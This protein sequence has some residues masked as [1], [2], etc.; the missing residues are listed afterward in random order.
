MSWTRLLVARLRALR[1]GSRVREE[2]DEEYQF[3]ID[4]RT[5]ENVARGMSHDDARRDAEQR[6]G[7]RSSI[8]EAGYDLRGGGW[9]ETLWQ[10]LRFGTRGLARNRGFAVVAVLTLGLGIGANTAIFSVINAVFLRPLPFAN[11]D[12]LVM[13]QMAANTP[14]TFND[15]RNESVVF[16]DMAAARYRDLSITGDGEPE[17]VIA[18]GITANL[19]PLLGVEP[20]LGRGF[21]A[22]E[23]RAD[24]PRVV[25]L[26]DG[27]WRRRFGAATDVVG[28][29]VRLNGELHTIV[30]VMPAEFQIL[31]RPADAWVPMAFGPQDLT[32][33]RSYFLNVFAR[34]APDVTVEQAD[35]ATAALVDRIRQAHPDEV[36]DFG[37]PVVPLREVLAGDSRTALLVLLVAVGLVLL[38][39]CIN[40]GNLL[41]SR[42]AARRREITVRA[43]L[44]ATSRR[45]LQQ[46]LVENVPLVACGTV[47]GL[48][49]AWSSM[50][51][52]GQL[53]PPAMARSTALTLDG[54]VL[55]VTLFVAVLATA[56]FGV[57]PA[58]HLARADLNGALRLAGART[59][60]STGGRLQSALIVGEVS[61]AIAL[62][63][64]AS[65]LIQSFFQL[66]GQY[67]D[68]DGER[69]ITMKTAMT[70]AGAEAHGRRAAFV[71]AVL[72]RVRTVPGVVAAGYTNALP[73]DYKG[74]ATGV[75]VEGEEPVAEIENETNT[76]LVTPDFLRALGVELLEGRH[77][78]EA[79]APDAMSVAIV[80]RAMVRLYWHG[81]DPIGRRFKVDDSEH[82]TPWI[83][84][85][86]VVEDLRQ[87]NVDEPARPEMYLPYVQAT[88]LEVFAPRTLAIR[89]IGDR[90]HVLAAVRR[91]IAAVNPNQP[92][93]EVRTMS[94]IVGNELAARRTGTLL[95]GAFASIALLLASVG[96]YGLLAHRVRQMTPEIGVRMALGARPRDMVSLVV[97]RGMRL[98]AIGSVLGLALAF[99]GARL[100]ESLLFGV[101]ANDPMTFVAV[102]L[103]LAGVA[104]AA[105][106]VPARYAA[107][108]DPNV[109]LRTE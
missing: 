92:I 39:A 12:R 44:G 106:C 40:V 79:D 24:G 51:F 37:A 66:R 94:E 42:A 16:A 41:L 33:R 71:G 28:R 101:T 10:D 4:L 19:L 86:G 7:H 13:V 80:N 32:N 67:G 93:A 14:A 85:V 35:A 84:V 2:I 68:L 34:L 87:T 46:L 107:S 47:V 31:R 69:V 95:L 8:A 72:D 82:A 70:V 57:M 73:L 104:L 99:A 75:V 89:T 108:I 91:E 20:A 78:T 6:F 5:D 81:A 88:Y 26:S 17:Q 43:A 76:R 25:L 56:M 53:I 105:V 98:V 11:P 59:G 83:T 77:L 30:G 1:P 3:H 90:S 74:D 62:L 27:L 22:E 63:V 49:F 64:G 102:P 21:V 54:R 103:V 9:I 100:V 58:A 52:L 61:L 38:I 97:R 96:L 109:A 60:A 29:E 15:L 50:A 23:D 48:A 45:V 55:L 36:P 65:L 18:Q